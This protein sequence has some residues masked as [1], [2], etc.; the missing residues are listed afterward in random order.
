MGQD[1]GRQARFGS[2]HSPSYGRV[3][4]GA[5]GTCAVARGGRSNRGIGQ[6]GAPAVCC[7]DGK[8][9]HEEAC[10]RQ[11]GPAANPG[12]ARQVA[13]EAN[14]WL[15]GDSPAI[16]VAI[17]DDGPGIPPEALAQVLEPFYTT[18]AQGTG[19][20][21]PIAKRIIEQ[22]HGRLELQAAEPRGAR[23]VVILPVGPL[24]ETS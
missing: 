15:G 17:T 7:A 1:A 11:A 5:L 21:L 8:C 14:L 23:A 2:R 16:R 12:G 24:P 6:T 20:G 10:R 19:L 9:R 13:I 4:T 22:H 3:P 18:R